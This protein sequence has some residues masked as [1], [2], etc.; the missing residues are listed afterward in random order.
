MGKGKTATVLDAVVELQDRI[1]IKSVLV[2]G[3]LRII[4]EVWPAEIEKWA[5]FSHL[6]S[7]TLH[8]PGKQ[9]SGKAA[10]LYLINYE[11]LMW[12]AG[13]LNAIARRLRVPVAALS[14]LGLFAKRKGVKASVLRLLQGKGTAHDIFFALDTARRERLATPALE[15]F[16]AEYRRR[17]PFDTVV[18]DEISRMKH[19]STKRFKAWREPMPLFRY[20]WGL[21]GTPA[22]NGYADLWGQTFMLDN[23]IRLGRTISSFRTRF[24]RPVPHVDYHAF[25]LQPEAEP[26]I[27]R[28]IADIVY[29]VDPKDFAD[30]PPVINDVWVTLSSYARG[31]YEQM[32]REYAIELNANPVE[33]LT[34][35]A[36]SSKLLQIA[37]GAVYDEH[38]DWYAVHDAKLLALDEILEEAA[39]NPVLVAYAFRHDLYR[40]RQRYPHLQVLG[41]GVVDA[42]N[43]GRVPL[44]AIHPASAGHGLNLQHGGHILAWYGLPPTRNLEHYEQT[45]ARLHGRHGQEAQVTVHRILAHDTLDTAVARALESKA[46]TQAELI[47]AIYDAHKNF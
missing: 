27:R 8:G 15:A 17:I 31:V 12:L 42:W 39:G 21:T 26:E 35:S 36:R 28:L 40:L 38:K 44:L 34:S 46:M 22:S 10:D 47:T 33:A 43:A 2:I 5:E 6:R 37:N 9:L 20:R 19:G 4:Q 18:F 30:A 13:E 3:T 7:I 23:G 14:D 1:E 24:M 41:P 32:W 29:E 45:I 16:E 11:G 25:E